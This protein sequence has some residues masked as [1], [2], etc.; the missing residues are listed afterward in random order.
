MCVCFGANFAT[1]AMVDGVAWDNV[2]WLAVLLQDDLMSQT[3][4]TEGNM[5]SI[6]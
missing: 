1:T 6:Q 5:L 2:G 4:A 3:A